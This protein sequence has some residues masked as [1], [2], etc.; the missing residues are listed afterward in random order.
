[1]RVDYF[2][3]DAVLALD[4]YRYGVRL[5]YDVVLPDPGARLRSRENELKASRPARAG[6]HP[7]PDASDPGLH[8]QNWPTLRG[9]AARAARAVDPDRG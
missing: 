2:R 7:R 9:A 8:W 6:S 4:L 3:Q 5:T 1:M